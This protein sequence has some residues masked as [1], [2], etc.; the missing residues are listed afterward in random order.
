MYLGYYELILVEK[1]M[2]LLFVVICTD[3]TAALNEDFK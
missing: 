3:L 2:F 1:K